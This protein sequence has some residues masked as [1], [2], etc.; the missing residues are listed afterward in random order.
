MSCDG[1]DELRFGGF[2]AMQ[3]WVDESKTNGIT[4]EVSSGESAMR[5][6]IDGVSSLQRKFDVK[7][8]DS[9]VQL[10]VNDNGDNNQDDF[11][12]DAS[13][14]CQSYECPTGTGLSG[15][16][17]LQLRNDERNMSRKLLFLF[18]GEAPNLF[19]VHKLN[20]TGLNWTELDG[21]D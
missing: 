19:F 2:A 9:F 21:V 17:R 4:L 15:C 20:C 3:K 11:F 10:L 1:D 14:Y 8:S 5:M 6:T 16:L 13:F 12:I 7:V 18:T